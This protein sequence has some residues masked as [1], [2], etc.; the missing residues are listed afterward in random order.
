MKTELSAE[1]QCQYDNPMTFCKICGTYMNCKYDDE[2][3]WKLRPTE[4]ENA[5]NTKGDIGR[6]EIH[7]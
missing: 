1:D 7:P 5:K 6:S 4:N 2:G 3:P